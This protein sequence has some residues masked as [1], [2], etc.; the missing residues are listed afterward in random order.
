MMAEGVID[1]DVV[2]TLQFQLGGA[3]RRMIWREFIL[4]LGL[5]MATEMGSASFGIYWAESARQISD[6]GNLSVNIPYL[7]AQ[8]LRRYASG[9]KRK[10]MIFGGQ[11]VARLAEHFRLLTDQRLQGL[12]VIVR[13]LPMTDM[14]EL[15]RLQICDRL[16]NN[17]AWVVHG[18][19]RQQDTATKAPEDIEGAH[20]EGE[21]A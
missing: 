17:W 16:D 20:A 19:E 4:A 9:R 21:G 11:F 5:Y 18:L 15:V 8:Y 14:D 3:K 13:G 12:M 10:A 1:L 7:L 2:G 6:K